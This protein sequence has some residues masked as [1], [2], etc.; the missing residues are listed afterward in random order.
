MIV[1]RTKA[2]SV[3]KSPKQSAARSDDHFTQKYGKLP[4]SFELNQGQLSGEVKFLSRGAASEI[5]LTTNEVL[6][7]CAKRNQKGQ[8]ETASLLGKGKPGNGFVPRSKNRPAQNLRHDIVRMRLV[9]ANAE[10][11]TGVDELPGTVNYFIGRDPKKWHT[12]V[13]TYSKVIYRS[14]YPGID[15]VFHGNEQRLEYDF[16]VSPGADPRRI[17]LAFAGIQN[18][19]IDQGDLVLRIA[20]REEIRLKKPFAYQEV[21]NVKREIAARYVI[22]AGLQVGLEVGAYDAT[23]P[24]IIDPVLSYSTYLGGSGNDAGFDIAVDGNGNTYVTGSTDSPEFSS[25]GGSNAFVA[26]LNANGTQR[27]YLAIIGG[28]G[29]DTGFS[30]AVDSSGDAYITG[31]TDSTDFPVTNSIQSSFGGGAQDAFIAKLDPTGSSLVYSTYLGGSG[32][33]TG[34]GIALDSS[35]SAYITGVTDSPEFSTLGN[36][37]VFVAKLN[38]SGDQRAYLAILGGT[39]DDTGFDIA[40]DGTGSAYVVGSTDSTNFTTANAWQPNFGGSQDAFVAK[41]NPTGSAL[42][43]S[44]YF[45][46]TGNDSGFGIAIDSVGNAYITGST[47]SPE[48]TSL[49][50]RDVFV[51]KFSSAGDERLYFTI[52]GGSGDDAGFGIA[53]DSTGNAYITG[54]TDS[55]N[56]TTANALQSNAAGSQ[57]VFV[58]KLNSAGSTL[59]YSTYLGSIDNESGFAIAVDNSGN[60]F[61]T[62]FTSSTNFPTA[63]PLQSVMGGNGDAFV[64]KISESVSPATLQFNFANYT[65]NEGAGSATITVIR[66]GDTSTVGTVDYATSDGTA[67]HRSDYIVTSGTLSFGAGETSKSFKVLVTDNVYVD[68]N[69]TLNITLSNPTGGVTLATPNT[70]VLTILDNDTLAPTT[71]PLDDSDARFFVRQHY[72][73]FLNREPDAGGLAFWV[74]SITQCGSDQTCIRNKRID[75]S[76]AFFYELEYQQTAAYVFRLYRA[77]FGN[78]QPFPN[79]DNANQ[80]EAKKIPSYVVFSNDRARLIGS[81][82][83]AQDQLALANLFVTRAEFLS[84]YPTGLTQ[85]QFVDALILAI[86]NDDGID[87]GSQRSA[88]IAL[89]SRGAVLYRIADDNQTNP[90]N[91]RVFIDAEYNRSFV[92]SQYFG[93]LRRDAEIGGFLFWL[94]QVSSAPLRDVPKQ[95]AM[96]CSFITSAEYQQRFSPIFTHTNAECPH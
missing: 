49:G 74:S 50:G 31:A 48:F 77:A 8:S 96:V 45:G 75:V 34:F 42:V 18:L 24:L 72:L 54:S 73:D 88:L 78:N 79:P 95:H 39:G 38:P 69:R 21:N 16:I 64:L 82:N 27:T 9:G 83:L 92:A 25:L 66:S 52:L 11:V 7:D 29:D 89:G 33:D 15:Q 22:K 56:F 12:N 80:T 70:A 43:Y 28:S 6:L 62:G 51:A 85:D 86:K 23:K 10:R 53:V 20:G 26:K 57:D 19:G 76:N 55:S 41:L 68:G 67:T 17:K 60:A 47:D 37:D 35:G 81:A 61:I 40:V 3:R 14:V 4:L 90:I 30:I 13:R 84:K 59:S 36:T 1:S 32:N 93:Y 87:L 5:Y 2:I 71:N 94:G 44:T 63:S 91:N 65:V 58:A 46:G